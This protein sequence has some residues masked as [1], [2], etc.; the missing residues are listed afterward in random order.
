MKK[1]T[2]LSTEELW[3]GSHKTIPTVALDTSFPI[4]TVIH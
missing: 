2:V 1:S 4:R 3:T